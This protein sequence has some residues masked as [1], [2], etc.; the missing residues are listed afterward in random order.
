[1]AGLSEKAIFMDNGKDERG[2]TAPLPEA[3]S[4]DSRQQGP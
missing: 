2:L 4:Q 3:Q 1:L